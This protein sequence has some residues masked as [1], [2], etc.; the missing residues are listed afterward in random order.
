MATV[1]DCA[2]FLIELTNSDES[3]NLM[4]GLRLNNLLYM[5]QGHYLSRYNMPLF[6]DDFNASKTGPAISTISNRYG[7]DFK[8]PITDFTTID[9]VQSFNAD[10]FE[11]LIAVHNNYKHLSTRELVQLNY[12]ENSPWK[13]TY[14]DSNTETK[15][16]KMK[17]VQLP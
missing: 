7:S 15:I 4:T 6:E 14:S 3:S 1:E 9:A 2:N 12:T 11:M 8:Q 13:R 10:E 5:A 16:T 17:F